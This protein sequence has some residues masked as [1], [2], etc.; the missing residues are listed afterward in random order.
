VN[1][2]EL[3]MDVLRHG[4]QCAVVSPAGLAQAVRDQLAAALQAYGCG[5][6][7]ETSAGLD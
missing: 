1:E 5:A 4:A 3:V 6:G 7:L 2:T